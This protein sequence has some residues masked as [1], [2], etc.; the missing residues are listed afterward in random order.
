MNIIKY[1]LSFMEITT[2]QINK[3]VPSVAVPEVELQGPD[4]VNPGLPKVKAIDDLGTLD[5]VAEVADVTNI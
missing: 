1:I 4:D 3:E 5:D 2:E